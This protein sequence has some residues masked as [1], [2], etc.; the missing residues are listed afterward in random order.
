MLSSI[1]PLGERSRGSSFTRTALGYV[2]GSVLAA[3][4]V[5]AV[6]GGLGSLVGNDV[7]ASTPVLA[8]LALLLVIGLVLDVRSGGDGVP[9]WQRQVDR[10]WIGRYRGWV[11]GLGFG[12]QL[13][14]GFVTIITSTTTYAVYLAELL[15]GRWWAGALIGLV[16][17]L[18]RALP[19]VLV[20]RVETPQRLHEVFA[21]LDS[22][23]VPADMVARASLGISAV[24]IIV[25][26]LG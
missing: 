7:R 26:A 20:C 9:S 18:V 21:R 4:L 25:G 15:T 23:A 5:G 14:L 1:S 6:L 12:L 10:E 16:F 24:V 11:T 8:V 17:G 22:W 3:V 19:L 13:G 2:V